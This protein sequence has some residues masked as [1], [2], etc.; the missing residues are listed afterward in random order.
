V[1]LGHVIEQVSGEKYGDYVRAHVFEPAGM[2]DS[3]YD[4]AGPIIKKRASGYATPA[5]NAPYLDMTLPHAAGSLYSTVDDMLTWDQALTAGKLLSRESYDKMWT[6]VK[7]D[8]AYGWI[9]QTRN[10]HKHIGH[11]GGIHGFNSAFARYPDD[12]LT[13]AVLANLNGPAADNIASG[14]ARLYFGEDVQP[15]F[16]KKE[17]SVAPVVLEKLAG[18]YELNPQ[19]K[20][21]VTS[22]DGKLFAQATGQGKAQV[23]PSS[24]TV[25]FYKVVDAELVFQRDESGTVTGLVL[26]QNGRDMPAKRL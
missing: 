7:N 13:I 6:P 15:P 20:I 18:V 1:L 21:A 12:K 16:E 8:Y 10:G 19:F 25:F 23:F 9:V 14:L 24:E 22:E 5:A 11:N 4:S 17:I 3:G 2:K 26:K